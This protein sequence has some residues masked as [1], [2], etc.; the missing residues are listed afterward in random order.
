MYVDS[1]EDAMFIG[2]DFTVIDSTYVSKVARLKD[3]VFSQLGLGIEYDSTFIPG[4]SNPASGAYVA[5][6]IRYN[7]DLI[8]NGWFTTAD[9]QPAVK[10]ARWDGEQWHPFP[11]EFAPYELPGP[12]TVIDGDLYLTGQFN[13]IS[14]VPARCIARWD[15]T[16]WHA[17]P[18]TLPAYNPDSMAS[19]G[20]IVPIGDTLFMGCFVIDSL[21]ELRTIARYFDGQ[22]EFLP[23]PGGGLYFLTDIDSFQGKLYAAGNF[24]KY[25]EHSGHNIAY[26][27]NGHWNEV[28][29]GANNTIYDIQTHNGRLWAVGQFTDIGGVPAPHVAAWDG[30]DWCAIDAEFLGGHFPMLMQFF[31]DTLYVGRQFI[32]EDSLGITHHC[33]MAKWL[34]QGNMGACGHVTSVE[35]REVATPKNGLVAFPNPTTGEVNLRVPNGFNN[36]EV[37]D[38]NGRVVLSANVKEPAAQ[39]YLPR[40]KTA[41]LIKATNPRSGRFVIGTVI[42]E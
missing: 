41:Y 22:W 42:V 5:N 16:Q 14:G 35:D 34:T 4:V 13:S 20:E 24:S 25:N 31:H 26:W 17:L 27:D 15:G 3:G 2:G 6:I 36:V 19:I 39:L 10:M 7:G 33:S 18:G 40:V 1:V 8:A 37:F 11:A 30:T 12:M 28:G 9:N 21:G 38:L 32:F 23:D 29:G